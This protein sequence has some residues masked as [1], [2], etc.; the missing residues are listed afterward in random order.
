M[1]ELREILGLVREGGSI[2]VIVMLFAGW[3]FVLLPYL[4]ERD[5]RTLE[6]H[7]ERDKQHADTLVRL[8]DTLGGR[9]GKIDDDLKDLHTAVKAVPM[10]CR[11]RTIPPGIEGGVTNA[12]LAALQQ[13][14]EELT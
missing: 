4:Q 10:R 7:K 3:R 2:A 12:R 9:L 13:A 1:N 5:A 14:E 11:L 6:S 8:G